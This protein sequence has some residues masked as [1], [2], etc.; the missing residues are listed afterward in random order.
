MAN[1]IEVANLDQLAPG[2]NMAVSVEGKKVAFFNVDGTVYAMDDAC[3]HQ[4]SIA[5]NFE[6]GWQGRHLSAGNMTS[7]LEAR[8]LC[9]E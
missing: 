2:R 1:Y 8:T 7:P 9:P 3:L 6:A 4:G 5:R